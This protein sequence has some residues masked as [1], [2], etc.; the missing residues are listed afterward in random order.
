MD[1]NEKYRLV[2]IR[3]PGK[4]PIYKTETWIRKFAHILPNHGLK[5]DDTKEAST[6]FSLFLKDRDLVINL[7][8]IINPP[9]PPEGA[10][11]SIDVEQPQGPD[12]MNKEALEEIGK[13]LETG[14]IESIKINENGQESQTEQGQEVGS[15]EIGPEKEK[16]NIEEVEISYSEAN[17]LKDETT[18]MTYEEV[19]K[20]IAQ[21]SS[22]DLRSYAKSNGIKMGSATKKI[23][24]KRIILT[25]KKEQYGIE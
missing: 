3:R 20:Y 18:D 7:G 6:E 19:E 23:A 8:L 2:N 11:E 5:V 21:L 15:E 10:G 9:P 13:N 12:P 14:E 22:D 24:M 1:T 16:E 25:G 17:E 4:K